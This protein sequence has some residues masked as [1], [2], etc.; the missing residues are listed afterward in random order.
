MVGESKLLDAVND[1]RRTFQKAMRQSPLNIEE[2]D[3][4]EFQLYSDEWKISWEKGVRALDL[5]EDIK[6]RGYFTTA[7]E[8]CFYCME[9][10]FEAWIMKKK[11]ATAF[12]AQHGAVFDLSAEY[13]LISQKCAINLRTLWDNYRASQYY[14]PYVPTHNT[15]E[16]M[17]YVATIA[18][19]FIE[20]RL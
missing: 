10:F 14:R 11:R 15:A 18:K 5:V 12:R 16:K 20:E 3:F 7:I 17:I 6:N 13:G 19:N 4:F 2:G 1:A 8:L 9:R